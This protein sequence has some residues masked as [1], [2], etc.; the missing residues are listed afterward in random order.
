MRFGICCGLEYIEL[1]KREGYDYCEL[2]FSKITTCEEEEFQAIKEEI[3]RVGLPAEAYNGFFGSKVSLNAEVDYDFIREYCRIGFARTKQLG[4]KVAVLG[5]GGARRIPEGYNRSLAEEQFVK[6]LRICG[7]EAAKQNMVVAIEPLRERECNFIN[8]VEE[9]LDF[10]RRA[11][12]PN[13]K[14]LADF[15]HVASSEEPLTAIEEAKH[16]LA[17]VHLAMPD[18]RYYPT[19]KDEEICKTWSHALK[20]CGYDARISLEGKAMPDFETAIKEA[21]KALELFR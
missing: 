19:T 20:Q 16:L 12:H 1:L 4:G 7:E 21:K 10:V 6:V 13:V 9:G 2:N 14:C 17:H 5:S 11:G 15:F 18:T 8:T 3:L